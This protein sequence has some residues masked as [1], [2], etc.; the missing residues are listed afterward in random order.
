MINKE[1]VYKSLREKYMK[2]N[3]DKYP[4]TGVRNAETK[5]RVRTSEEAPWLDGYFNGAQDC[6]QV[7]NITRGKVYNV[8]KTIGYGD[9]ESFV[10]IN[11]VG[12]EYVL[13]DFFFETINAD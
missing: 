6:E 8:I 7:S 13:C 2:K 12:E 10:V 4:Y 3:L 1:N 9:C 5:V 11:D